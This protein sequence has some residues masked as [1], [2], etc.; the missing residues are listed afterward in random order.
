M[1][2]T[3]KETW[4]ERNR[5]VVESYLHHHPG[6]RVRVVATEVGR[7]EV[8]EGLGRGGYRVAVERVEGRMVEGMAEGCG[9]RGWVAEIEGKWRAG[10]YLYSHLT[11]YLRFCLLYR[12]GGTYSDMDAVLLN[13]LPPLPSFV[14]KDQ[15]AHQRDCAWCLPGGRYYLAPGLLR[16][17]PASPLLAHALH[18][19]FD[20]PYD[21]LDF[22]AVG[23]KAFTLAYKDLSASSSDPLITVLEPHVLYPFRYWEVGPLFEP[24][25]G[26]GDRTEGCP[27]YARRKGKGKEKGKEKGKGKGTE[28][29]AAG[30]AE[31]GLERLRRR[32]LSLHLYGHMSSR[33]PIQ[34]ASIVDLC[35]SSFSLF[36]RHPSPQIRAPPFH[37]VPL[38]LFLLKDIR[39]LIPSSLS[40]PLLLNLTLSVSHGSLHIA[41]QQQAEP[42]EE[43]SPSLPR[44]LQWSNL[45]FQQANVYLA[46][47]VYR[48][49]DDPSLP[50]D[51][52]IVSISFPRPSGTEQQQQQQGGQERDGEAGE[53]GKGRVRQ[54]SH[55]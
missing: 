16:A 7:E 5:Q 19:A 8:G 1:W 24:G 48:V 26:C 42:A 6:A 15:A 33:L 23:P 51:V 54:R 14:G 12:Q 22:G 9:G 2:T 18:I 20:R 28:L 43:P 3:G 53:E 4:Q 40:A 13:P 45:T 52:L 27:G 47:L 25:G 29:S 50:R 36:T 31:V 11:D 10:P 17:P 49:P 41:G 35:F 55:C 32:S 38:P 39:V 34:P 30:E 37:P 21:P 44:L 46:N